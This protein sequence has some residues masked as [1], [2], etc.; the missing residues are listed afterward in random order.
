RHT[1][2][3]RDWSSDV[4]S[5]DLNERRLEMK[6]LTLTALAAS[7]CATGAQALAKDLP[8]TL[9]WTAYDVGSSGYNQA[10]AIGSQMKSKKGI[11]LRSEE[12]RVGKEGSARRAVA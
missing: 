2:I 5:S 8:S 3:S 7:L 10:V 11:T 12:R 1:I 4:C 6:A 9:A